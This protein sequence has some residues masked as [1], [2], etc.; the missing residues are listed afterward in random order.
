MPLIRIRDLSKAETQVYYSG[1]F[2]DEFVVRHGEFLIGMDGNFNIHRWQGGEGL[3]NQR[4]CRL[5]NF[6]ASVNRDFV[7]YAMQEHLD[8]IHRNTTYTTVKHISAKQI[9]AIRFALPPK[10]EQE[11]IVTMV[12]ELNSHCDRLDTK[13]RERDLAYR[14]LTTAAV[15]RFA[16]D[17]TRANLEH[18]FAELWDVPPAG[19]RQ[20]I[21]AAATQGR[22]A[23]QRE[24]DGSAER[25]V[26]EIEAERKAREAAGKL[27]G[28]VPLRDASLPTESLPRGWVW[29]NFGEITFCRDGERVP[30]K[31][32]DRAT[33]EKVYDYYGA[34][35]VIDKVEDYLFAEPLLLIG[36]DGANLVNRSTPIAFMADGKYW[37]NN[38]AHV[39]DA[40]SKDLLL[41]LELYINSIPLEPYITGTAQPKMNQARMNSIPVPLP[42]LA[43]QRRIVEQVTRLADLVGRLEGEL[44]RRQETEAGLVEALV[45]S[46]AEQVGP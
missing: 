12:E 15:D 6:A 32:A 20:S 40:V 13:Y 17:P 18:L 28:R 27:R 37:V 3:L 31:R 33:Q 45:A 8:E 19:L 25:L 2:R 23:P 41:Y 42:P 36:E 46:L 16:K 26:E 22:L 21:L 44:Q 10:E 29:K 5:R 9:R 4:V 14:D 39:I 1:E 34:S 7:F 30:V 43:E 11:R 38:H 35:G 24:E